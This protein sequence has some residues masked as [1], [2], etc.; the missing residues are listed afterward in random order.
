MVI[1]KRI[2]I[3]IIFVVSSCLLFHGVKEETVFYVAYQKEFNRIQEK[4]DKIELEIPEWNFKRLV[5]LGTVDKIDDQFATL[6]KG[7]QKNKVIAGHNIDLIFHELHN[8]S[9]GMK[10]ML[11]EYG[12]KKEYLVEKIIIVNPEEVEC[13]KETLREQLTLITCAEHDQKRLV[14]I[15]NRI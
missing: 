10:I 11:N 1:I 5:K 4:P 8:L 15:C 3:C 9:I 6:L 2:M 7:N 14:V 12:I 13:L